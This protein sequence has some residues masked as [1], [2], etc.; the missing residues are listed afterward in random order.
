[1]TSSPIR[2]AIPKQRT[3]HS[4]SGAT[5]LIDQAPFFVEIRT[6][7]GNHSI[8]SNILGHSRT[9]LPNSSIG[10]WTTL[11]CAG[12]TGLPEA[13]RF[14]HPHQTN[15]SSIR[16]TEERSRYGGH[17]QSQNERKHYDQKKHNG[18]QRGQSTESEDSGFESLAGLQVTTQPILSRKRTL[19]RY[20]EQQSESADAADIEEE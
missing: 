13:V 4:I 2:E 14:H 20:R 15:I 12:K 3:S 6:R 18:H 7:L 5:S 8:P 11:I 16:R 19:V 1:M 10:K 9:Q 17:I